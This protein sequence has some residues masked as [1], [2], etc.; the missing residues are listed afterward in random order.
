M[1]RIARAALGLAL[2]ALVAVPSIVQAK[3]KVIPYTSIASRGHVLVGS[4]EVSESAGL[5]RIELHDDIAAVLQRD[6]GIVSLVDV[7]NPAKPEV[8]GRYDDDAR[9]SLDGDIVFS[10]DGQWLI[11]ARQTVQFS[12]DGVHVIDVSD[13]SA[14]ALRSYQPAG[15]TLRI[16][17]H[18][19]GTNEWVVAMDAIA[20]LV[21]YRFEP[22]TGIL[23]PVHAS[24]LP[25]TSK[26]GGPA[27]AGI[28]IQEDPIE[29]KTLLY[30]ASG[31]SGLEVFDFSDPT[32]PAQV[33][34]WSDTG[35]AEIEVRVTGKKRT[36][37]AA[38]EYWFDAQSR[39]EIVRL[40]ATKL[41]AI[42]Q[43]QV[44]HLNC[45]PE[46]RYRVQGMAFAG[47]DLYAAHSSVGLLA[48]WD[49]SDHSFSTFVPFARAPR[50]ELARVLEAPYVF[51]VEAVG[52]HLYATDAATGMLSI[53]ERRA[54]PTLD[55]A[56]FNNP[57]AAR[58]ARCL[59]NLR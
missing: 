58:R 22:T 52:D 45:P 14:P 18:D 11:Y 15:G 2:T 3:T 24:P 43:T 51:D 29:K 38:S 41:G 32:N 54:S 37:F 23:I 19:D 9:Q 4:L 17:H 1:R 33:G 35:L 26:V 31:G 30:A 27:S 56:D 5:G 42:K 44:M 6:E 34:S 39:P 21:V 10:T 8:V 53:I 47:E 50:N 55:D 25:F 13:P 36:V 49:D 7:A 57:A 16:A 20:G 46:D 59:K 28:V 40:D 48:Y 12:L